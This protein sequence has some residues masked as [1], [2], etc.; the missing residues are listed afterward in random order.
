MTAGREWPPAGE[1]L[2][3]LLGL[4][5]SAEVVADPGTL[6]R[7]GRERDEADTLVART[8][9]LIAD[10]DRGVVVRAAGRVLQVAAVARGGRFAPFARVR[11]TDL[12]E[13]IAA[14]AEVVA[15]LCRAAERLT[16]PHSPRR[17]PCRMDLDKEIEMNIGIIGSGNIGATT[18]RLFTGA[19][20]EVTIA[21]SRGPESL[22]ELVADHGA[23]RSC[24]NGRG[25]GPRRATSILIAIPLRAYPDLPAGAFAGKIVIDAN[26]YY[27]Q[28]DGQ[29]PEL[30]REETTS[31]ELLARHLAGARV[32][33]S[34]NTMN[35]RPLASEGRPDAP[36]AER[37][38]IYLAGD[39]AQAKDVVAAL[40]DEVGF[41]PVDT[42]T[43]HD[44]GARQQPGSPI[45]N[46]PMTA[47]EAEAA[48][49]S[50]R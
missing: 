5:P 11:W 12:P 41:A 43:L 45:Y 9:W 48:V 50:R 10:R 46:N 42:G 23:Q 15:P 37:L 7:P 14:V 34:F 33:K 40:I 32:V 4:S 24:G 16:A 19:G 27:P 44:G 25:R 3:P 35:F 39:D 20:H 22:A 47:E 8:A 1:A 13:D 38:A 17:L 49:T 36:R 29:I 21:N 31:S 18:A 28:R 30:D 2:L 26:N 6:L